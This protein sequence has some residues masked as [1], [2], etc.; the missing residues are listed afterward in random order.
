MVDVVFECWI[1]TELVDAL[2]EAVT[3]RDDDVRLAV[4]RALG[5]RLGVRAGAD[6][7]EVDALLV[8]GEEVRS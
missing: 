7:I 3:G 8:A 6:V 1:A 2:R 4:E 5:E